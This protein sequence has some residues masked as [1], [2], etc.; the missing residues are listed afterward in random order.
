MVNSCTTSLWKSYTSCVHLARKLHGLHFLFCNNTVRY[1]PA[2]TQGSCH[3]CQTTAPKDTDTFFLCYS[4]LIPHVYSA[5]AYLTSKNV[6]LMMVEGAGF[7][8]V[9]V[10]ETAAAA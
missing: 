9:V 2:E 6:I 4:L 1:P 3:G 5:N 7:L 10:M 8:Q